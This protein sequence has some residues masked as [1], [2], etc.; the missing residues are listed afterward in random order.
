MAADHPKDLKPTFYG[1]SR[2]HWDGDTLVVD[3]VGFNE[4]SWYDFAGT[5]HTKQMH[6]TETFHRRD[7]GDMEMTGHHRRPR[8]LYQAWVINRTTTLETEMEMTEYVCNENNQDPGHLDAD[9]K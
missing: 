6:L 2:A 9:H 8:R 5:P 7:F 1:D 3:T 4:K